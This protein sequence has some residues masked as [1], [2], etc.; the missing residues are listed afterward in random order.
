MRTE[1]INRPREADNSI[2]DESLFE[3]INSSACEIT[4][5]IPDSMLYQDPY[6]ECTCS[7][8]KDKSRKY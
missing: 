4:D 3:Y 6:P 5:K 7:C 1:L 8:N 2:C